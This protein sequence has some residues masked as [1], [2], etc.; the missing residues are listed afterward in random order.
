MRAVQQA[1]G[2][3]VVRTTPLY[4]PRTCA[5]RS[6][7]NTLVSTL[8]RDFFLKRI[9]SGTYPFLLDDS[10]ERMPSIAVIQAVLLSCFSGGESEGSRGR[11]GAWLSLETDFD[12]AQG[13]ESAGRRGKGA[14]QET[15]DR[16]HSFPEPRKVNQTSNAPVSNG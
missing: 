16:Q 13:G 8:S 3:Q 2:G 15:N 4:R 7:I 5:F 11:E 12:C 10:H 14:E 1:K 9:K 6:A